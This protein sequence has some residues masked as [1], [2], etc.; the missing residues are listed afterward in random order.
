MSKPAEFIELVHT[1][2]AISSTITDA[3]HKGLLQ[4]A[5]QQYGLTVDEATEIL[6]TAGFVVGESLNHF[7][8]LGLSL[9][10]LQYQS[11]TAIAAQV[12]I[13]HQKLY[14]ASLNA[15]GA[16]RPDGR[17]QE[18][19]RTLLNQ[20]R[21]TLQDTQKRKEHIAV[22]QRDETDPVLAKGTQGTS[23]VQNN[24]ETPL[25]VSVEQTADAAALSADIGRIPA[26][27]AHT[28]VEMVLIP[29]GEFQMG[30]ENGDSDE[31]PVHTVYLD[32]FYIDTFPVTNAQFQTFLDANPQWRKPQ[33]IQAKIARK[34]HDG[35][36]LYH[37]NRN[38]YPLG[39]GDRPVVYV[40][41]Y[42]AMAYAEWVGKRLPTEAEWEKAAR[43]GLV[44]KKYPTG[45]W[46]SSKIANFGR[47]IGSPTP[48]GNYPPNGYGLYDIVG[49]IWEWCLDDY[50]SDA[51]RSS[52][53]NNAISE[54][55]VTDMI[56]DWRNL[57]G[58][59]K[60]GRVLRGGGWKT[61]LRNVRVAYR[62]WQLSTKT[63][64]DIGFRCV[65]PGTP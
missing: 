37:W 35:Y 64:E 60:P 4:K 48:L 38:G 43:G 28:S 51:Y 65:K 49:N 2:K 52:I 3:Q 57:N 34:Y 29:A 18:Q 22:L 12:D 53:H 58:I 23:D 50:R 1:L 20:A 8:I 6:K 16:P 45:D 14:R 15:G 42:A 56:D 40:S 47:N 32:A 11:D 46:L 26:N 41:W 17:T 36:Y 27:N 7:E 62:N 39:K 44:G 33:W 10:K 21:D 19:W 55:S 30:S 13:S 54:I 61:P 24:E 9:E 59:R 5:Y 25:Q 63:T 31:K